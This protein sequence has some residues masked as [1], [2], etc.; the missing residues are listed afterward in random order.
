MEKKLKK[1]K[2]SKKV[3]VKADVSLFYNREKIDKTDR[4]V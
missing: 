4:N 2:K 1:S 3:E